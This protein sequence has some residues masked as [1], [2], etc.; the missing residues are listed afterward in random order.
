[1]G[2]FKLFKLPKNQSFQFKP[3]YW[4]PEKEAL[5]ERLEQIRKRQQEEKDPE[6]MKGRIARGLRSG[7]Q[8][9]AA[10]RSR[11]TRR[12]NVR[13]LLIILMLAFLVYFLLVR[14]MP[15]LIQVMG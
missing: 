5:A 15:A 8:Q 10:F 1:M 2:L 13:L 12:S 11:L 14:F 6:G 9:D 3:R 4:D 7:F